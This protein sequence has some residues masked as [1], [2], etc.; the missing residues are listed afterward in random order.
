MPIVITRK[1]M[2][3][4]GV[5][6]LVVLVGAGVY[7][8]AF[9]S[10]AHRGAGTLYG[11]F[12]CEKTRPEYRWFGEAEKAHKYDPYVYCER[13]QAYTAREAVRCPEPECGRWSLPPIPKP[14]KPFAEMDPAEYQEWDDERVNMLHTARC[15]YC[16][17]LLAPV[18]LAREG[19]RY[20]G[21]AKL[22][23]NPY[24]TSPGVRV[25]SHGGPAESSLPDVGRS[26]PDTRVREPRLPEAGK[27]RQPYEGTRAPT[28]RSPTGGPPTTRLTT[29][30][31]RG[32]VREPSRAGSGYL[33][34]PYRRGSHEQ[35]EDRRGD[36]R[37]Y[38]RTDGMT[39]ID[40]QD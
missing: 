34:Q 38:R 27:L 19:S 18:T 36:T 32:S 20:E 28:G 24:A 11:T 21:G 25:P 3:S 29:P 10:T 6:A 16:G 26:T 14:A 39:I 31:D 5:V 9:R 40:V 8:L 4:V 35:P 13:T 7:F 17:A 33:T 1:Q 12:I 30:Y 15:R 23:V 2:Q 37:P 22:P